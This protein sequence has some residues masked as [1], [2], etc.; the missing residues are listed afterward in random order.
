LVISGVLSQEAAVD[1]LMRVAPDD[2]RRHLV[3]SDLQRE[4]TAYMAAM[5][6]DPNNDIPLAEV[7]TK[8]GWL[9]SGTE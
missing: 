8:C 2:V 3:R 5:R 4:L 9:T 7:P 1:I 6:C